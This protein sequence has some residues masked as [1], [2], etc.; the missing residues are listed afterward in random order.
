MEKLLAGLR[1]Q[2]LVLEGLHAINTQPWYKTWY[3]Y[4]IVTLFVALGVSIIVCYCLCRHQLLGRV[5]VSSSVDRATPPSPGDPQPPV[6]SSSPTHPTELSVS[7]E[8]SLS[9]MPRTYPDLTSVQSVLSVEPPST[10]MYRH[11][12]GLAVPPPTAPSFAF[13]GN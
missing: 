2:Q 7:K 4:C 1:H 10:L 11:P 3:F 13:Y 6:S 12:H 9:Q 5:T 8:H